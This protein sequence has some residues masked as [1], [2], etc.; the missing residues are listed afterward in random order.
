MAI[1]SAP[2]SMFQSWFV[3]SESLTKRQVVVSHPF[4]LSDIFF[5]KD[6]KK[7]MKNTAIFKH[8]MNLLH[9]HFT[10]SNIKMTALLNIKIS[11]LLS[12]VHQF[13]KYRWDRNCS[14]NKSQ[15]LLLRED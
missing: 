2:E 12:K 10:S 3:C 15:I 11:C 7:I 14:Y 9:T 13:G 5:F 8:N 1:E 6:E 4:T